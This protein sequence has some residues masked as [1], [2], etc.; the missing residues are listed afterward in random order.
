MHQIRIGTGGWSYQDWAGV[1]YPIRREPFKLI[2]E[3]KSVQ[4]AP[5]STLPAGKRLPAA[6][7]AYRAVHRQM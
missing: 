6:R 5:C 7:I 4:P 3:R 2:V 1:F